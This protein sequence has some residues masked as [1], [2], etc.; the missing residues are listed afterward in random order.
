ME[1]FE[2]LNLAETDENRDKSKAQVLVIN[3]YVKR[4]KHFSAVNNKGR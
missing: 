1:N 2:A 4:R 3:K